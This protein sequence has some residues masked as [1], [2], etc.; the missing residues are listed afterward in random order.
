MNK[1]FRYKRARRAETLPSIEVFPP[2]PTPT[3]IGGTID[4]L[5]ARQGEINLFQAAYRTGAVQSH[6]FRMSVGAPKGLPGWKELDFLFLTKAGNYVGIQ[7]KDYEFV[8]HGEAATAEDLS[9]DAYILQELTKEGINLEG[10]KV[11]SVDALDLETPE[12]A[13]KVVEEFLL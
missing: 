8:H 2:A 5:Q 10:N 9:D 11:I 6:I 4:G 12:E 7:V 13:M 3:P 1:P